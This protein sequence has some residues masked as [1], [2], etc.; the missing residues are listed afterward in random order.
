MKNK[1]IIISIILLINMLPAMDR[2]KWDSL[3][4]FD[5]YQR[6]TIRIKK[7]F[8][9]QTIDENPIVANTHP[10][11]KG[12]ANEYLEYTREIIVFSNQEGAYEDM[13]KEEIDA[14][15]ESPYKYYL[16]KRHLTLTF[17]APQDLF[18]VLKKSVRPQ[19]LERFPESKL[20]ERREIMRSFRD[21]NVVLAVRH[22]EGIILIFRMGFII[23]GEE[24]PLWIYKVSA[25]F[26][27]VE[28]GRW[29]E[30]PMTMESNGDLGSIQTFLMVTDG[31]VERLIG[32]GE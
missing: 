31:D 14:L 1:K 23:D 7:A 16:L 25:V 27:C 24:S 26:L 32:R 10:A 4:N 8:F 2:A 28:D 22:E 12:D 21:K 13:S 18:P 30:F 11:L 29:V 5:N 6:H 9:R 3:T 20:E 19:F 17:D 15:P